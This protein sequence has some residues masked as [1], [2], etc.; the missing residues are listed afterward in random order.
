MGRISV[1][2]ILLAIMVCMLATAVAANRLITIPTGNTLTTGGIKL[3]YAANSS[4]SDQKIYWA[5]VGVSR[6]EVEGAR[7]AGFGTKQTDAISLQVSVMPETSFTPGVAL[8]VRDISDQT[9]GNG[10]YDGRS[11][12]VAVSKA[13]PVTGGIPLIFQDVRVHS[14]IGTGSLSGV[15]F[16]IEGRLPMG[17][18]VSGEY[19]TSDFNYAASYNI[20]PTIK[21]KASWIKGDFF[22]GATFATAF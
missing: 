5:N 20:V 15:F 17:L 19:D 12:Y 8:G 1:F 7:F 18:N 14:G 6:L 22:Y 16:G 2:V 3:E 4:N 21:A 13:V 11:Y 10:L 9:K